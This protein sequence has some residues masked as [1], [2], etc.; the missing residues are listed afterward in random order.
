[1]SINFQAI[2]PVQFSGMRQE[3]QARRLMN[4]IENGDD[5]T[6]IKM[7]DKGLNVDKVLIKRPGILRVFAGF[8]SEYG[9]PLVE[10]LR[11]KNFPLAQRMIEQYGLDLFDDDLRNSLKVLLGEPTLMDLVLQLSPEALAFMLKQG[12]SPNT[13]MAWAPQKG[14]LAAKFIA[15]STVENH[16]LIRMLEILLDNGAIHTPAE[17]LELMSGPDPLYPESPLPD[18]P[19]MRAMLETRLATN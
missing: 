11:Q 2:H 18:K 15:L 4:A 14:M 13:P 6:A 12:L 5:A 9:R 1:V 19:K 8:Q 3:R 17:L 10:A 16:D 7:L